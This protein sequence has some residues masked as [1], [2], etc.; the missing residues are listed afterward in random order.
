[1][2]KYAVVEEL[3]AEL[4]Y[5]PCLNSQETIDNLCIAAGMIQSDTGLIFDD[6]YMW[7]T[8]SAARFVKKWVAFCSLNTQENVYCLLV[9]MTSETM[10]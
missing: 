8:V 1:M 4:L 7:D 5:N 3:C 9:E 10:H 6:C 2:Q